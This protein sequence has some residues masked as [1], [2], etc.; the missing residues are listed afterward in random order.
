MQYNGH[1][2]QGTL[3]WGTATYKE[4]PWNSQ[5]PISLQLWCNEWV[6]NNEPMLDNCV[7]NVE[8][9]LA[10]YARANGKG[11]TINSTLDLHQWTGGWISNVEPTYWL[12]I[13]TLPVGLPMLTQLWIYS[14][15]LM[16]AM[17]TLNQQGLHIFK[18][19]VRLPMS[20]QHWIYKSE[21]TIGMPALN[22]YWLH[23]DWN[24]SKFPLAH[25]ASL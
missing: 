20:T 17:P 24:T 5:S 18:R 7:V 9:I 6:V 2:Q 22:Q 13:F 21:P 4:L 19:T 14:C 15:G 11:A 12:Q 8:P 16:V 10:T 1:F 3:L 23:R 25:W